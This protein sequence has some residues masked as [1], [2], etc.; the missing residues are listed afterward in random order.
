[1]YSYNPKRIEPDLFIDKFNPFQGCW[2]VGYY[3][4]HGFHPRL[5]PFIHF[6]DCFEFMLADLNNS[7]K[8]VLSHLNFL[9]LYFICVL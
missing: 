9:I 3:Y 2:V 1:M 6:V 8:L 4:F 5:L 7:Q